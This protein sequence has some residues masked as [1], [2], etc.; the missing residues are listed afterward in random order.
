MLPAAY[1]QALRATAQ[2]NDPLRLTI[3]IGIALKRFNK[4]SARQTI[5]VNTQES[6]AELLVDSG[7]RI[8]QQMLF[9]SGYNG[10]VFLFRTKKNHVV[11][12]HQEQ[13]ATLADA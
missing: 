3:G 1:G 11:T 2:G 8:L 4:V 13:T 7:K 9:F 12:W 5:A 6:A 10:D